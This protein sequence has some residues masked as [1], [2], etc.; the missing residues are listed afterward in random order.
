[1]GENIV[2]AILYK[3]SKFAHEGKILRPYALFPMHSLYSRMEGSHRCK[4][5]HNDL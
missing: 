3:V 5:K 4:K 1:M 2:Y